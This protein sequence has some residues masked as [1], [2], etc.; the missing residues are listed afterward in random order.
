[1]TDPSPGYHGLKFWDV[2]GPSGPFGV[3]MCF[4]I[5]LRVETLRDLGACQNPFGSFLLL[6]GLETLSLRFERHCYNSLELARWLE[7]H[8]SVAWVSYPGLQHHAYHETAKK[9][10]RRG[11][12]GA[13]LAFGVK[14]GASNGR[15]GI[16]QTVYSS[17]SRLSLNTASWPRIWP[18]WETP[19]RW[20]F[21]RRAPRTSNCP[22]RN[23]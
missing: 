23:S 18:T 9:Y 15:V 12:F 11:F 16:F 5:R 7:T 20:S 22:R 14:G 6:Q 17:V 19:R 13:V 21:T 8:K 2:F 3:N 4:A 10:F 1:M